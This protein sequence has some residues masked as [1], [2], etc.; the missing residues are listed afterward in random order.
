M[1]EIIT[2]S[3]ISK[4]LG[5]LTDVGVR[6][7]QLLGFD[8]GGIEAGA[9]L[10]QEKGLAVSV[11]GIYIE[12]MFRS[13]IIEEL[14]V[15]LVGYADDKSAQIIEVMTDDEAIRNALVGYG[16]SFRQSALSYECT[17]K[18]LIEKERMQKI[19]SMGSV[20]SSELQLFTFESFETKFIPDNLRWVLHE[21]DLWENASYIAVKD[22]KVCALCCAEKAQDENGRAELRLTYLYST[23]P[24]AL[25]AVLNASVKAAL[26]EVS[27]D[28]S[29]TFSAINSESIKLAKGIGFTDEEI[30]S[31]C[32]KG[33]ILMTE[34]RDYIY[35]QE[36]MI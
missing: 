7:A 14:A 27:E 5:Y 12:P 24:K 36:T 19:L 35:L 31:A 13:Q 10:I 25:A 23:G 32:D 21:P 8:Y 34:L 22:K 3:N 11:D 4:Y 33:L 20:T 29:F 1:L 6:D 28:S 16:F 2:E 15:Y 18:Q 17:L 26:E 30:R 9:C